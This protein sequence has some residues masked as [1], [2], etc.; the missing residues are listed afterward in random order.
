MGKTTYQLVQILVALNAVIVLEK[1]S[2]QKWEAGIPSLR[3][4]PT[5]LGD[6]PPRHLHPDRFSGA[7]LLLCEVLG[8]PGKWLGEWILCDLSWFFM[9]ESGFL[10][11]PLSRN[12]N[13]KTPNAHPRF[14]P[15]TVLPSEFLKS[16]A[17]FLENKLGTETDGPESWRH[18]A[19]W[20][21]QNWKVSIYRSKKILLLKFVLLKFVGWRPHL[22]HG[23][24]ILVEGFPMLDR[25]FF[26]RWG[27]HL[28]CRIWRMLQKC[29]FHGH[30]PLMRNN[31]WVGLTPWFPKPCFG[32]G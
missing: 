8:N 9:I 14:G 28:H 11:L 12:L 17:R 10:K 20:C 23:T 18:E 30:L 2:P 16:T 1:N 21:S 25:F 29:R 15:D 31:G 3:G 26:H 19:K 6:R 13:G 7:F 4:K 22:A 5:D 32:T 24:K 27:L